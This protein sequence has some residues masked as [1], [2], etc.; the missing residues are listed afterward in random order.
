MKDIK[1][2]AW[3]YPESKMYYRGYQKWLHVLLCE[4]DRGENGGRGRPAKRARYADCDFMESTGLADKNGREIFERDIL[5]VRCWDK[6]FEGVVGPVPD[7]FGSGGAHP[8]AG[9]LKEHGFNGYPENLEMEVIGN[10]YERI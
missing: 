10:E 8:L 5:R 3:Y 4:D 7:S 1:F 9:L 2:R 6:E